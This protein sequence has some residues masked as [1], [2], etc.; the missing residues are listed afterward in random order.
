MDI[1]VLNR[2]WTERVE[3][4]AKLVGAVPGVKTQIYTPADENRYPTLAISWDQKGWGF[5]AGDCAKQ[6]LDGTPSIAVLTDDNP[7]GVLDRDHRKKSGADDRRPDKL[8]IVSMTL[9]PGEEIIVGK[10]IRQLLTAARRT[11]P[12][13]PA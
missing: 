1:N 12:S 6:L 3:R 13:V 5:S 4:I 11:T 8:Q 2:E 7:S 10:R 9:R